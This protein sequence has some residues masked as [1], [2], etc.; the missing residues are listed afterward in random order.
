MSAGEL[1]ARVPL[2][3]VGR[4][5]GEQPVGQF[6]LRVRSR[7]TGDRR[8]DDLDVR[9]LF[10]STD[11]AALLC[12]RSHRLLSTTRR[13]RTPR[14]TPPSSPDASP[15]S[16]SSPPHAA[17]T[18]A[19][20]TARARNTDF[21]TPSEDHHESPCLPDLSMCERPH[22]RR[23]SSPS[24][25]RGE[26]CPDCRRTRRVCQGRGRVLTRAHVLSVRSPVYI[27]E[28][29]GSTSSATPVFAAVT[30]DRR[31]ARRVLLEAAFGLGLVALGLIHELVHEL[32]VLLHWLTELSSNPGPSYLRRDRF[33]SA[34]HD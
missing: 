10:A 27:F 12:P 15:S 14:W 28:S 31:H 13:I 4:I 30:L 16:S 24:A 9:I 33:L 29:S 32:L 26:R 19:M 8:V 2:I 34:C 1:L 21:P 6:G 25:V 22:A 11:R 5:V 3:R 23:R 17:N 18:R 7:S 20:T